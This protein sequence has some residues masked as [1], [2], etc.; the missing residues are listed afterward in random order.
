MR[1]LPGGVLGGALADGYDSP[2]LAYVTDTSTFDTR[3][4]DWINTEYVSSQ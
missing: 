4:N 2:F 3:F 1:V